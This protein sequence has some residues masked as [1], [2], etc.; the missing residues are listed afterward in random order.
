[1]PDS[2]NIPYKIKDAKMEKWYNSLDNQDVVKLNRYLD[3]AD[4]STKESFVIS[5][6]SATIDDSNYRFQAK[7]QDTVDTGDFDKIQKYDLNEC[8]I[9][10][11][12]NTERYDECLERCEKGLKLLQD[13]NVKKH[14]KSKNNEYPENMNCR[15]YKINVIVGVKKDFD[16]APAILDEFVSLGLITKEESELRK[17]S[18]KTYRLQRTFEGVFSKVPNN[19]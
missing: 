4:S 14:V 16:S 10:A 9:L 17:Q 8:Q 7:I 11:Y 12:F 13:D 3:S 1:M 6:I 2:D 19:Q 18:I 5:I 15:N